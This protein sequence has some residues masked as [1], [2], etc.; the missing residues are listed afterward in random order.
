[1]NELLQFETLLFHKENSEGEN[2]VRL[3]SEN[4]HSTIWKQGRKQAMDELSGNINIDLVIIEFSSD[5][6]ISIEFL[7]F[8]KQ[9]PRYC[10]LPVLLVCK[11]TPSETIKESIEIGANEIIMT[12]CKDELIIGKFESALDKGKISVLIVDD[13]P[14]ILELLSRVI[15]IERYKVFTSTTAEEAIETLKQEKIEIVISDIDLPGKSGI[16]LL[17]HIKELY[18]KIP[19]VL[20]TGQRGTYNESLMLDEGADGYFSKPFKN[21]EIVKHLRMISPRKNFKTTLIK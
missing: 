6:S 16:E 11:N 10:N 2:L 13:E 5:I 3:L 17:V 8:I 12:P 4:G 18:K 21:T 15:A 7:K 9:S 1:M 19:V 14:I 20:V